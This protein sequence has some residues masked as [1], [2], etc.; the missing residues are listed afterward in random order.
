MPEAVADAYKGEEL[1][2][3]REY[4]IPKPFDP[5]LITMV[6]PAVA[7]A[8]A[9]SR[10]A[11]RPIV[12]MD[13]YRQKLEQA[14]VPLRAR[15]GAGIRARQARGKSVILAEGEDDRVLRA[16]QVIVDES[17]ATPLLLGRRQTSSIRRS[18][19]ST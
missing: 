4:L 6:A 8:A 11:R 10:V 17:I 1:R 5:R 2:F 19:R 13:A 9:E 15:Y 16:A 14:R 12:D 18:R 3:G 7:R